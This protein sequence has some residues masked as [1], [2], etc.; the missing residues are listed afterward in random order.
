M[1]LNEFYG[2]LFNAKLRIYY[3][4]LTIKRGATAKFCAEPDVHQHELRGSQTP[5]QGRAESKAATQGSQTPLK[6][7]PP[8]ENSRWLYSYK[9]SIFPDCISG[10]ELRI[11]SMGQFHHCISISF[12]I[13]SGT[14]LLRI[15]F[16]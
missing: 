1:S 9:A 2:S 14:N 11:F 7:L 5:L 15:S 10:I 8:R 12:F 3:E 13:T 16:D 6:Q 4:I